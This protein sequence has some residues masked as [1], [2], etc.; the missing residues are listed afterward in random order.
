M[1]TKREFIIKIYIISTPA[2][3]NKL[4]QVCQEGNYV[5]ATCKI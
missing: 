3:N 5:P 1:T 2:V 4:S